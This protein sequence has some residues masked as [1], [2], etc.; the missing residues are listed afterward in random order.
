MLVDLL[1]YTMN[2]FQLLQ[3]NEVLVCISIQKSLVFSIHSFQQCMTKLIKELGS[4]YT[5]LLC[6]FEC[7]FKI[8][9]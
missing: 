4:E 3:L 1:L 7:G 8:H 6:M 5:V 2:T 9:I